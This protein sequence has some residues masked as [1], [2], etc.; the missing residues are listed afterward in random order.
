MDYAA[1][2]LGEDGFV[3]DGD[4]STIEIGAAVNSELGGNAIFIVSV[5]V[6]KGT[7]QICRSLVGHFQLQ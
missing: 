1:G 7:D 5:E 3:V 6:A 4:V 2:L